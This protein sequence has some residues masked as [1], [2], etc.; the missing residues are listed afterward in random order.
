MKKM[1]LALE[2][3]G[4]RVLNIGYPSRKHDIETLSAMVRARIAEKTVNDEEVHFV[5]HSMGGI[6][7]RTFQSKQPL[8][9]IGRVVMLSPPNQG[10][11]VV[12]RLGKL[13]GFHWVNGPAGTQ[14]GTGPKEYLAQLGP[15]PFECGVITGDRSINWIN[16]LMIE[17]PD[18]GKVSTERAKVDGM[19]DYKVLHATHPMIMKKAETIREVLAFLKH[20]RF[21][22]D[23]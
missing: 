1:Q 9:N 8:P 2:A 3:E 13:R 4:Y 23:T 7:V 11:E 6:L 17:G 15:V 14:L 18:D 12:D 21:R 20:G 10:S 16:S 19:Q 22:S 5:T